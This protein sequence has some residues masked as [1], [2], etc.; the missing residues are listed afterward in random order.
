[1]DE[2]EVI[3]LKIKMQSLLN[4]DL[5]WDSHIYELIILKRWNNLQIC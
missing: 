5:I 3:M 1:M 4:W 2:I